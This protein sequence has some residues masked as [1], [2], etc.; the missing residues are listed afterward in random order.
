MVFCVTAVGILLGR[1]HPK[2]RQATGLVQLTERTWAWIAKN[3]RSSNSAL[4]VGDEWAL[5]VDP[6]LTPSV[7]IE[8]LNAVREVTEKPV[9]W[10][11]LTH[12]HPDH[13]L[14]SVCL[15]LEGVD[16]IAHAENLRSLEK[17]LSAVLKQFAENA[18]TEEERDELL[19]CRTRFPTLVVEDKLS[20]D[21]GNHMIEVFH[22]GGAHTQG[23]IVVWSPEERVLATGDLFL[24]DSPPFMGEGSTSAWIAALELLA[25]RDPLHVVPGHFAVGKLTDLLKFKAYLQTLLD[26]TKSALARGMSA[27]DASRNADFPE[28][29][30]FKQYPQYEATFADNARVVFEELMQQS[31]L[32]NEYQETMG[33]R[34]Q[35]EVIELH[36]FFQDWFTGRL[37]NT[38]ENFN[39]FSS[40]IAEDFEH[41]SPEGLETNR[42]DLIYGLKKAHT[43]RANSEKPYRVWIK[44]VRIRAVDDGIFIVSYEEW[45]ESKGE[46]RGRLSTALFREKPA[47]PNGVEW[48]HVQETWLPE[49]K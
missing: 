19:K 26:Y 10:V 36:Q 17:N 35:T 12:W 34:L 2:T 16:L 29:A 23:D 28:F 13:S 30:S 39:R 40:V 5:V 14:G 43:S 33:Q 38:D 49:E 44:N 20:L 9:R 45:Q 7:V 31:A 8:F 15:P 6:G 21:L 22:V 24:H 3:D 25:L 32:Q 11:V 1:D 18:P 27:E 37:M 47:T 48:L 42:D 46:T 4:F 41:I